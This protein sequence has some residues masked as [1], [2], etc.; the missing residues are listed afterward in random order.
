MKNGIWCRAV[1]GVLCLPYCL[2]THE[3]KNK[4]LNYYK[5]FLIY[6]KYARILQ[7]YHFCNK[8][9]RGQPVSLL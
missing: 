5:L 1:V 6:K 8:F 7:Y 9:T 4:I 3:S 2:G